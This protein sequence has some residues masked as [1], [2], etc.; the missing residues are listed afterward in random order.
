MLIYDGENIGKINHVEVI[1]FR[2]L[3]YGL[4]F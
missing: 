4:Q 3:A 1:N 2:D